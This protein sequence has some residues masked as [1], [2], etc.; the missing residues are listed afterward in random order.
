MKNVQSPD[1]VNVNESKIG[2]TGKSQKELDDE[3][4]KKKE[5]QVML[6]TDSG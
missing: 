6:N 3:I 5:K 4:K 2:A 1:P